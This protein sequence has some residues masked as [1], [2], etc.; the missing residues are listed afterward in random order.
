[1]PS[2]ARTVYVSASPILGKGELRFPD[3]DISDLLDYTF[4]FSD[5]LRDAGSDTIQGTPTVSSS[6]ADLMFSAQVNDT[7]TVTLD[8]GG[9]TLTSPQTDYAITAVIQTAA[10]RTIERTAYMTTTKLSVDT[11][12]AQNSVVVAGPPGPAVAVSTSGLLTLTDADGIVWSFQ[13]LAP[14]G[15][16][17]SSDFSTDYN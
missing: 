17:Y 13:G 2:T 11:R 3:R 1:M 14:G 15:I 4:D 9:G 10:G 6:P 16:D 8:I 12:T 7:T 5:F